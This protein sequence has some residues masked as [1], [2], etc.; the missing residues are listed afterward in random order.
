[1]FR[2]NGFSGIG[3]YLAPTTSCL[4]CGSKYAALGEGQLTFVMRSGGWGRGW[5]GAPRLLTCNIH[6]DRGLFV[7]LVLVSAAERAGVLRLRA[8]HRQEAAVQPS[9]PP[10]AR[11]LHPHLS[12]G[13]A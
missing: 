1:M 9:F 8:A 7:R 12:V 6:V 13:Q 10:A 3:L 2:Y 4:T 11:L 5:G